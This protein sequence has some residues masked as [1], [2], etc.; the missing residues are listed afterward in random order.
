[1]EFVIVNSQANHTLYFF[2]D[3]RLQH[4]V[5]VAFINATGNLGGFVGPWFVGILKSQTG[6]YASAMI[7]LALVL[8]LSALAMLAVGRA[9]ARRTGKQA[10]A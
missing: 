7:A 8:L 5:V 10:Y 1:M 9:M 4:C 2:L 6:G 3:Q